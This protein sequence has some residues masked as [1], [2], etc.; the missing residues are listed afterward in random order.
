MTPEKIAELTQS[1]YPITRH[2]WQRMCA[3]GISLAALDATLTYGR[4]AHIRNAAIYAIGRSEVSRYRRHGADLAAYEGIQVVCSL[5]GKVM[6]VYR[7]H[8]FRSLRPR[9]RRRPRWAREGRRPRY[10]PYLVAA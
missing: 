3:R 4:V 1:G 8:D 6:T 9:R 10:V 7:N 5:D 2:A